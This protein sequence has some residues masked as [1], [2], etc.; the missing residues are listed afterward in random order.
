LLHEDGDVCWLSAKTLYMCMER[1][2]A[3]R[4]TLAQAAGAGVL[5]SVVQSAT[6]KSCL[7]AAAALRAACKDC[8]ENRDVVY[9]S[10][11]IQVRF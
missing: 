8:Q 9:D 1:S 6:Q 3:N 11:G 10:R 2:A 7:Y 5:L 4:L